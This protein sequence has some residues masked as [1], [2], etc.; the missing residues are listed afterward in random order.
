MERTLFMLEWMQ[1][2][3]LRKRVQVGLNKGEAR[4][5]LARAVFFNRQGEL[6]DRTFENQRYR[7]SGLNLVVLAIILWNTMYLERAQCTASTWDRLPRCAPFS[8]LTGWLGAHQPNW[9]LH[10]APQPPRC[11]AMARPFPALRTRR[12]S[13]SGGG[14]QA[15]NTAAERS[16]Q[17]SARQN[18][19]RDGEVN[20]DSHNVDQGCHKRRGST[21]RVECATPQDER[22]HGACD[23]SER[24]YP[25]DSAL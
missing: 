2:P 1:D 11:F 7:A 5:A 17:E 24:Y 25:A 20:D 15:T 18:E 19:F 22:Q 4:N 16:S 6:R 21:C 9:G 3:E 23:G 8:R 14:F 13:K 12:S 10:L